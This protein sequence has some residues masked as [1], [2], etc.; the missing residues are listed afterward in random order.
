MLERHCPCSLDSIKSF[1]ER[2]V[3][4]ELARHS[5]YAGRAGVRLGY[6]VLANRDFA[7]ADLNLALR[8]ADFQSQ[9]DKS[10]AQAQEMKEGALRVL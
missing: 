8:G 4:D 1:T 7:D 10:T 9:F 5:L 2:S 6:M 3:S